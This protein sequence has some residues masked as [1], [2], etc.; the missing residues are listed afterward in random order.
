[1]FR[2]HCETANVLFSATGNSLATVLKIYLIYCIFPEFSQDR[3]ADTKIDI[4]QQK[5]TIFAKF[6]FLADLKHSNRM[7]TP[8]KTEQL[9]QLI[10]IRHSSS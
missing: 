7:I 9:N 6:P 10:L 5:S 8:S 3:R 4:K 1:M 2:N